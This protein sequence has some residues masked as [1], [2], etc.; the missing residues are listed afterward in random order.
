MKHDSSSKGMTANRYLPT[1]LLLFTFL[2]ASVP[3]DAWSNGGYSADQSNPD[4]GTHDWIAEAALDLQTSNVSF[5]KTTYHAE[6][7]LG[8][9]APDNPDFIGDTSKHHVYYYASHALQDD[10][11]AARA[12]QIYNTAL[13]YMNAGDLHSASF[14]IGVMAHYVS[15]PGVFGHT[16]GAYTD[17]GTETHHPD[18]EDHFESIIGGLSVPTGLS[19]GNSSAYDATLYLGE[20]TTFGKD[21]IRP[22][23]WMDT[24][25]NWAE[26][27][28][29]M[30][31][32]ASLHASVSAVAAVI[33]HLMTETTYGPPAPP[34][35]EPYVPGPP[36][37]L[38]ATVDGSHIALTWSPPA[39]DGGANVAS[40]LIFRGTDS[41][42]LSHV[43]TVSA[44][45]TAWIDESPARGIS[46]YYRVAAENSMG[47]GD[48]SPIASETVPRRADSF[49]LPIALSAISVAIVSGAILL[50]RRRR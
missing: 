24:N 16:M 48:L 37:S 22:N 25:Y 42:S 23:V 5:L 34:P 31:A 26:G 38:I 15:D 41:F 10:A 40:Y 29:S 17:W 19:L 50:W 30:S 12:S 6:F 13:D 11:C 21:A 44:P 39:S 43:A 2:L 27:E 4:Y 33:N 45:T 35:A 9:E 8:T 7:L 14:D 20:C 3:A 28:F 49:T 46:Y 47:L 1:T 36:L 18:Y 32:M